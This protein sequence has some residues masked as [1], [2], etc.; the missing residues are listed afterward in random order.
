MPN[1]HSLSSAGLAELERMAI[2]FH[3]VIGQKFTKEEMKAV[4]KYFRSEGVN[5]SASGLKFFD[6]CVHFAAWIEEAYRV[7]CLGLQRR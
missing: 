5:S 2:L 1:T 3:V 4:L 6:G 7:V